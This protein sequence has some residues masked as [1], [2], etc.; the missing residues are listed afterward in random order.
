[1]LDDESSRSV[2]SGLQ[3]KKTPF[4]GVFFVLA[5]G[6]SLSTYVGGPRAFMDVPLALE[7]V[8]CGHVL[9]TVASCHDANAQ[10][11]V[12]LAGRKGTME[13]ACE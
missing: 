2:N 6:W 12:L 3:T 4:A 13:L 10:L 8:G 1:M 9:S 11:G 7:E 5:D